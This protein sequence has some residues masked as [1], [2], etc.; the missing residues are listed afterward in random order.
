MKISYEWLKEYVD[1]ELLP[2]ELA[3][4]LT[5]LGFEASSEGE[6]GKHH[7]IDVEVTSNRPDCLCVVGLARE[8]SALTGKQFRFPEVALNENAGDVKG[9][10]SV[11]VISEL[12]CRYCGRVITDVKVGPSQGFLREKLEAI[13]I[14]SV[15]NVVDITNYVLM[16]MGHPMHAFDLE[17]LEGGKIVV[18]CAEKGEKIISLDGIERNLEPWMLVIADE[19]KPVAIA[20]I[21]GGLQSEVTERTKTVLL[22]SAYFDPVIVRKTSKRL[23]LETESSYRFQRKADIEATIP[24]IDRV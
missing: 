6:V 15:N 3:E 19:K 9:F 22:E 14:R 10:M 7:V 8:V 12:C 16:E 5:M 4:K 20:G 18:R 17:L 13:G 21:M 2:Q 1:A 23:Q 11:E 24:A